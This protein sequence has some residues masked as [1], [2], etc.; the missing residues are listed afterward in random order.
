MTLHRERS[1]AAP[2]GWGICLEQ[3]I[4]GATRWVDRDTG[5]AHPAPGLPALAAVTCIGDRRQ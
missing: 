3:L 2:P 5:Q 1:T 4:V